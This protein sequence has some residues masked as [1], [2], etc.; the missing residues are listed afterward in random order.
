MRT[1]CAALA[2]ALAATGVDAAVETSKKAGI[3]Y[4][5]YATYAWRARNSAPGYALADDSPLDRLIKAAADAVL[6]ENGLERAPAGAEADVEIT[7]VGYLEDLLEIEGVKREIRRGVTWI[8]DPDSHSM[9]SAQVGTLVFEI[10][11]ADS[12]DLVWSGWDTEVA[13]T[14]D[15]IRKKARKVARRILR[16]FPPSR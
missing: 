16:H 3:D 4:Q 14:R 1:W 10:Y 2:I 7:Y 6:E 5:R 11:D 13:R 8:G 12:G 9:R 15:Q